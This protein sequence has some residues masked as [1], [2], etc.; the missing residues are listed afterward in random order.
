M[1]GG[2]RG[3]GDAIAVDLILAGARVALLARSKE[4]F[5]PELADRFG[6]P[7]RLVNCHGVSA[8]VSCAGNRWR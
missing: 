4:R 3:I 8:S 6:G 7:D 1:T 2:S 5:L